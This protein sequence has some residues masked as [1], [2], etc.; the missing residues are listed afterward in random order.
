M[1][2]AL[3]T[4]RSMMP[5]QANQAKLKADIQA[6]SPR[7]VEILTAAVLGQLLDTTIGTATSGFQYGG[8]AGPSG[9]NG[10]RFRIECKRYRDTTPFNERELLGEFHQALARDPALE[11]WILVATRE[12]PEQIEQSLTQA[13]DSVGVPIVILD[14]KPVGVSL[15]GALCA[16][17]PDLVAQIV[18]PAAGQLAASLGEASTEV[19]ARIK[20]DL[21]AWAL[22]FETLRTQSHRHL[23]EIWESPQASRASLGQDAAVGATTR[24]VRRT[25]VDNALDSWW[26]GRARE[27]V[28]AAVV[29]FE[30]VGKTWATMDWLVARRDSQPIVLIVPA[31]A[32]AG[33]STASEISVRD[34]LADQLYGLVKVRDRDHWVR[35]L[36]CL[37]KRPS[38]EGPVMTVFL[39]GLNQES[40]VHWLQLLQVLQ[41]RSFEGKVRVIV[42]TRTH[43]YQGKLGKLRSLAVPAIEVVVNVYDTTDGGELDQLLAFEGLTRTDLH[44]DL[45][46]IARTPR[47]FRLVVQFRDRLIEAGQVTVHRLLWEY[48]RDTLGSRA[49]RSFSETEWR[50]WLQVI[51]RHCRQGMRRV[52]WQE[53]EAATGQR[54]LSPNEVYARLSDIVDGRFVTVGPMG[55]VRYEPTVV[56]HALAAALLDALDQL[57]NPGVDKINAELTAWLDPIAGLDER[58]EILRAAVSISVE[59]EARTAPTVASALV[60]NWLH[61]QNVPDQHRAEVMALAANLVDPLLGAIENSRSRVNVSAK[62]WAVECL[63]SIERSN[64]AALDSIVRRSCSWVSAIPLNVRTPTDAGDQFA[65]QRAAHL[66]NQ[67]GTDLPGSIRVLGVTMNLVDR[68]DGGLAA[69]VP[70]LLEGF[71]L[72]EAL[73]VFE[74]AAIAQTLNWRTRPWDGLK[75]LCLLNAVDADKT[76]VALRLLSAHVSGRA[77]EQGINNDLPARI[78]ALLLWMTGREEDDLQASRINPSSYTSHSYETEYLP[79]PSTSVFDLERRHVEATLEEVELPLKRRLAR[80]RQFW[81]DPLFAPPAAFSHEVGDAADNVDVTKLGRSSHTTIQDYEFEELEPA[82]ARCAPT[83]LAQLMRDRMMS[84]ASCVPDSRYWVA[85]KAYHHIVLAGERESDAAR[86]LRLGSQQPR[87]RDEVVV[88]NEL[89]VLELSG[90]P[91]LAQA[92]ALI[93]AELPEI[94]VDVKEILQPLSPEEIEGLVT[95]HGLSSA[96]RKRAL[97]ILVSVHQV[98]VTVPT[99]EWLI[100]IAF[101]TD[102]ELQGFAFRALTILDSARFGRALAARDWTWTPGGNDWVNDYGSVALIEGTL[103]IPFE[104]VVLRVAP[105]RVLELASRRGG[106]EADVRLAA[107]IFARV[108]RADGLEAPDAGAAISVELGTDQDRVLRFAVTPFEP[109]EGSEPNVSFGSQKHIDATLDAHNR[110]AHVASERMNAARAAG[111]SL[112]LTYVDPEEIELVLRSAPSVIESWLEGVQEA[113]DDFRRRVRLAEAVYLSLCEALLR[114]DDSRGPLLWRRLEDVLTTHFGSQG[115]VGALVHILFR[116]QDSDSVLGLRQQLLG[117]NRCNT[118]KHLLDLA[119]A[120]RLNGKEEWIYNLVKEDEASGV[121]WR[122]RRAI[123]LSGFATNDELR[124]IEAWPVGPVQTTQEAIRRLAAEWRHRE[125]WARVWWRRYLSEV[126]DQIAFANWTLFLNAADRRAWVWMDDDCD[127]LNPSNRLGKRRLAHVRLNRHSIERAA[128]KREEKLDKRFLGRDIVESVGP[129]RAA[130]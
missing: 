8:D 78:A 72:V 128:R 9:R 94:V 126:E 28:P 32:V 63:R 111:A 74:A 79:H 124:P 87:E 19:I 60:T 117:L 67:I 61:S 116:V 88:A 123:M 29:G 121:E 106:Q 52:T 73:P 125:A 108:V 5:N 75:W 31:S 105:W 59:R 76:A 16:S 34:F 51:A 1:L 20:R 3:I 25:L 49:G 18:S 107:Q 21:E 114:H 66:R 92:T 4:V 64:H 118:D 2:H 96:H 112:Y 69:T 15:L 48:G 85:A 30:G 83:K 27:D 68:D 7:T 110:A 58:A 33:L 122:R 80:T 54:D 81:I 23:T 11:A 71:P 93:D 102:Q 47:L 84:Y 120:A 115:G 99:W 109:P 56:T 65:Q 37:L 24:K 40:S 103:G 89:L 101:G 98:S 57:D 62:A 6:C 127:E 55:D 41:G 26:I 46:K 45:V 35:R 39:D 86:T 130:R 77:P 50:S 14:W 82:L 95:A 44:D 36:D 42:S 97:L 90:L 17:A 129:W 104:Q 22:G 53:L 38:H 43:Y 91:A 100:S 10:R 119:I 70:S 13:G 12:V 113:T